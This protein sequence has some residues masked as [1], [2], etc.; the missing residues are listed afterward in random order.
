MSDP[1]ELISDSLIDKLPSSEFEKALKKI[2]LCNINFVVRGKIE[3]VLG[4]LFSFKAD[5]TE[6]IILETK[7]AFE[8]AIGIAEVWDKIFI[9]DF[10]I[11]LGDFSINNKGLFKISHCEIFNVESDA[12][13]CVL[14]LRLIKSD[15]IY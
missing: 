14:G 15:P 6:N 1:K 2:L 5:E 9:S 10:S 13:I 8:D 3:S 4:T 7:V 12:M 11:K